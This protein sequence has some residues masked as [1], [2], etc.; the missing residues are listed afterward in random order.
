MSVYT[1]V[2]PR[3]SERVDTFTTAK[4]LTAGT[5]IKDPDATDPGI[6]RKFPVRAIIT[7]ED[8]DHTV[9]A[10]MGI[11]YTVD[12]T[13]PTTTATTGIGHL[14]VNG[15]VIELESYEAIA[16]FKAINNVASNGVFI[17]VT[18]YYQ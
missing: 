6:S 2:I 13:T 5:Y 11:R 18:Y 16:N 15:D 1:K 10:P 14:A 12:G 8:V 3:A 4:G 9:A 7:V 17:Q